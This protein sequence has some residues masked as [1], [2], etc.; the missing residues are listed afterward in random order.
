ME[1][2]CVP[3]E[4]GK[5][6][7]VEY[8]PNGITIRRLVCE[9]TRV[10]KVKVEFR[11]AQRGED[12]KFRFVVFSRRLRIV[13]YNRKDTKNQMIAYDP[14]VWTLVRPCYS[15]DDERD[16]PEWW[17]AEASECESERVKKEIQGGVK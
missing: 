10:L 15:A 11:Y 2:D 17:D 12:G 9:C 1:N 16:K 3:F 6:Y 14:Y 8:A 7:S 5:F 13:H 4:V